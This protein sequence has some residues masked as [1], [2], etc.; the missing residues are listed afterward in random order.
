MFTLPVVTSNKFCVTY[1]SD[2]KAPNKLVTG[3]SL[4]TV[5]RS[6]FNI[7][8]SCQILFFDD[9]H[10]CYI[11][12][13]NR[14]CQGY[15]QGNQWITAPIVASDGSFYN[16]ALNSQLIRGNN[17]IFYVDNTRKIFRLTRQA[18]TDNWDGS[19]LYPAQVPV[20]DYSS[21]VYYNYRLFFV[22]SFDNDIGYLY[23]I[24]GAGTSSATMSIVGG[25]EV[26]PV[27]KRSDFLLT[28]TMNLFYIGSDNLVYNFKLNSDGK[29][30]GG[31][32]PIN[33]SRLKVAL[34]TNIISDNYAVYYV[35]SGSRNIYS[36]QFSGS[37]GGT[38]VWT[39]SRISPDTIYVRSNGLTWYDNHIFYVTT[40]NFLNNLTPVQNGSN[41]T[42]WNCD[43]MVNGDK[44]S[45][46]PGYTKIAVAEKSVPCIWHNSIP[47]EGSYQ[48]VFHSYHCF[49]GSYNITPDSCWT[50]STIPNQNWDNNLIVNIFDQMIC[51]GTQNG[52]D[53][54]LDNGKWKKTWKPIP[55]LN[56][57]LDLGSYRL[58][59]GSIISMWGDKVFFVRW[60]GTNKSSC[61]LSYVDRKV[62]NSISK[63]GY[64]M[65]FNDEF[66]NPSTVFSSDECVRKW[67]G[68][69]PHWIIPPASPTM[70]QDGPPGAIVVPDCPL[71]GSWDTYLEPLPSGNTDYLNVG[72]GYL[73]LNIKHSPSSATT[74]R[75]WDKTVCPW[76]SCDLPYPFYTGSIQ[77]DVL[78]CADP[79]NCTRMNSNPECFSD[80]HPKKFSYLYGYNEIRCQLPRG[81][82]LWPC[83]GSA[84]VDD[85]FWQW[86]LNMFEAYGNGRCMY[87]DNFRGPSGNET[88]TGADAYTV[89]A[90]GFRFYDAMYTYAYNWTSNKIEYYFN[91]VFVGGFGSVT[92]PTPGYRNSTIPNEPLYLQ[93]HNERHPLYFDNLAISQ[94]E[95]MCEVDFET[96]Q[97]KIDYIRVYQPAG[98]P[99]TIPC[100]QSGYARQGEFPPPGLE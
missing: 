53:Q 94:N 73:S 81:Q 86:N 5:I 12:G 99:V 85:F 91:N 58:V 1:K 78:N 25:S 43:T 65:A 35:E 28:A 6:N 72:N 69:L 66:D 74:Y 49:Y 42:I 98:W 90:M 8:D 17:E 100:Q 3:Y 29:W 4:K 37:N 62:N 61:N 21:L 96:A 87:F 18:G 41:G 59:P 77:S 56:S 55:L 70:I 27:R 79:P 84:P 19:Y 75:F 31:T 2:G 47:E 83:Y 15:A 30:S 36:V 92:N 24:T 7:R 57:R 14:V 89:L 60:D 95:T 80:M 16:V 11:D 20:R 13:L 51:F 39:T 63:P 93:A 34:W 26:Q 71:R 50:P 45:E 33:D 40:K 38:A 32:S 52:C 68:Q 76:Y 67:N 48:D 23:E 82:R 64:Q 44:W 22:G 88:A 54:C 46:C 97:Y 10:F 9:T